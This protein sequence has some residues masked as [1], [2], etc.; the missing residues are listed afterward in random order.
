MRGNRQLIQPEITAYL[1][2]TVAANTGYKYEL[3]SV[4]KNNLESDLS[5]AFS[6]KTRGKEAGMAIKQ[7]KGERTKNGIALKWEHVLSG[8][9]SVSIYRKE[10][11]SALS[12]WKGAEAWERTALDTEAKQNT[13][14][15]YLLV[16]KN[17]EGMPVSK[18]I[19]ID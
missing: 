6:V 9:R 12:L 19:K 8:V 14:Y 13:V 15:E 1:D 3:V 5:P 10:G 17:R 2:S 11:S 16:I 18:Q 4:N 7:F